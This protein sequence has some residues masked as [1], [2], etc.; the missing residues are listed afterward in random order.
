MWL[1]S[2]YLFRLFLFG[3]VALGL[4]VWADMGGA[5]FAKA[6]AGPVFIIHLA[7]SSE[8]LGFLHSGLRRLY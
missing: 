2:F 4:Y 8:L 5:A 6:P 3:P 7:P 1:N